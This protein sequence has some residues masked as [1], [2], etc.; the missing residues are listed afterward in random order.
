MSESEEISSSRIW[1]YLASGGLR[2]LGSRAPDDL[3]FL[4]SHPAYSQIA[5]TLLQSIIHMRYL[6]KNTFLEALRDR[7]H[8][9]SRNLQKVSK[10]G[11]GPQVRDL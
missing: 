7:V 6:H 10:I 9:L 3:K 1:R 4:E 11:P 8:E 5:L 2:F